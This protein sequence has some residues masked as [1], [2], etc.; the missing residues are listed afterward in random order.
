M[1]SIRVFFLI[2]I[3]F[4]GQPRIVLQPESA[5]QSV[6]SLSTS[7]A[8]RDRRLLV[9][10][11]SFVVKGVGYAPTP[12]GQDPAFPPNGD[13]FTA[14]YHALY[15]RDLNLLRQMG[16][17]TIRLWGWRYDAD[18]QDFLDAAYNDGVMPIYVIAS[19][20]LDSGRNI[21]DPATRQAILA[22][23]TSMVAAH[24]SHPAVLMWAIGNELNAPW[25]FGDQDDLF[26]LLDDM[27]EAAHTEEGTIYHPVTTP[28]ADINLITT[29]GNR[30][31]QVPHLD[32]WSVQVYRGAS[33]Y[34]LFSDYAAVSARPLLI[35]EFGID[36]YDDPN[37]NEFEK[38]GPPHQALYA[39]SLW[40][41]IA[42]NSGVCSGGSIMAYSDEWWKGK[43]GQT[44]A[45]HPLC[46]EYSAAVHSACGYATGSHP[47]GYANEEWW[48]I[49]RSVD[50]GSG[51]DILQPRAV[52]S[53]LQGLWIKRVLLPIV[54]R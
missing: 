24:K 28:L 17:N 2:L 48:G 5:A 8:I 21:S 11:E 44:D 34:S 52:Y 7:V 9:N 32:L 50:H 25:M 35:T 42:A 53:T 6:K 43:S 33:F 12:I 29:I 46:P 45:G 20:W 38:I 40:E 41:E 15:N 39:A 10:G 18:H 26:S 3:L 1:S 13:Y 19:Y 27:A 54:I 51:P 36:A 37:G 16:A 31:S 30:D 47:D 23:F 49:M 4:L 14:G 22:E